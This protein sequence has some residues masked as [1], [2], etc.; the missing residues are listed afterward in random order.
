ML[1]Y[2]KDLEIAGKWLLTS[3]NKRKLSTKK[4]T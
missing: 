4:H 2:L 1:G 3:Q